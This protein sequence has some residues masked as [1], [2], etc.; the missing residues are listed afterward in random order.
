MVKYLRQLRLVLGSLALIGSFLLIFHLHS[1]T[2]PIYQGPPR[3]IVMVWELPYGPLGCI[4]FCIG[5]FLFFR[6]LPGSVRSLSLGIFLSLCS[7]ALA[8]LFFFNDYRGWWW[9]TACVT[10][11]LGICFAIIGG[12]LFGRNIK[13]LQRIPRWAPFL[14]LP[15]FAGIAYVLVI[16]SLGSFYDWSD[17]ASIR[18]NYPPWVSY[19]SD[20]EYKKIIIAAFH[21]L[22][23]AGLYLSF[24]IGFLTRR[25]KEGL[26]HTVK[27]L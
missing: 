1:V 25:R 11:W 9:H 2:I 24:S 6:G 4:L 12:F 22:T 8:L 15:L 7:L 3:N 26:Q 27:P 17:F 13:G 16:F 23:M 18:Y 5:I 19:Y 21:I 20:Y 10:W 14:T